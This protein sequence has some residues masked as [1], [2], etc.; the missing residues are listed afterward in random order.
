M[1]EGIAI[2]DQKHLIQVMQVLHEAAGRPHRVG[3]WNITDGHMP[4]SSVPEMG[5][6]VLCVKAREQDKLLHPLLGQ[7]LDHDL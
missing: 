5:G 4:A 6:N 1:K 3:F 7:C 2:D